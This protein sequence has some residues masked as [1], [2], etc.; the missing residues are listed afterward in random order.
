M[1]RR[2][3]IATA[4]SFVASWPFAAGA[5]RR[6]VPLIGYLDIGSREARRDVLEGL[7]RGLAESGYVEGTNFVCE[8]RW[9]PENH[10]DRLPVLAS[11]LVRLNVD[12]L[13]AVPTPAAQA[14]KAATRS[15][16]IVFA[17]AV[18]PIEAGLVTSL[19]RPGGNATGMTGL[20]VAVTAK[21]MSLLHELLPRASLIGYIMNPAN[22]IFAGPETREVE[23]AAQ[24]LGLRLITVTASDPADFEPAF[25]TLVREQAG[26]VLVSGA[27]FFTNNADRLA[28]MASRFRL[29]AMYARRDGPLSGGLI[30]FGTD[31]GEMYRQL[32]HYAGRILNG[33]R[34]ADLPVQ[35]V[36]KMALNINLK[37]AK[38]LNLIIPETLLATADEV[39]E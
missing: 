11:E 26:A 4:S 30:S 10:V 23:A 16:P 14:A 2:D 13:V 31:F 15:I 5:Q 8:Y 37:T 19:A 20:I 21:R 12:L 36:V 6:P 32:G 28:A 3:F 24:T 25:Q 1:R 18:D 38:S 29:P 22:P 33:E 9:A 27:S 7:Q 39:I 17:A 35:Q 34:P